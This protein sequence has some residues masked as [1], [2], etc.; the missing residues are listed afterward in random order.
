M[1]TGYLVHELLATQASVLL[2]AMVTIG[3]TAWLV[4]WR[5]PGPPW[6]VRLDPSATAPRLVERP[7]RPAAPA[8]QTDP[9]APRGHRPRAPDPAHA[10]AA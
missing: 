6:R 7:A 4:S 5:R 1:S 2:I 9:D 3:L 8:R 10:A